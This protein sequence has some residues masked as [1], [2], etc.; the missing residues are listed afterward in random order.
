MFNV[1]L[2]TSWVDN[3]MAGEKALAGDTQLYWM[4]T[5]SV[6]VRYEKKSDSSEFEYLFTRF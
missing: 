6:Q 5:I 2:M 3:E 1:G 4:L